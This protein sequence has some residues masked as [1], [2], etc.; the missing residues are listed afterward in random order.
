[1]GLGRFP[2]NP[3]YPS[4]SKIISFIEENGRY[5]AN[6][7]MVTLKKGVYCIVIPDVYQAEKNCDKASLAIYM[8]NL[9]NHLHYLQEIYYGGEPIDSLS[10]RNS[11]CFKVY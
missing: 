8:N 11:Y 7:Q 4:G 9:D 1:V 2:P 3:S 10:E 5:K 6:F